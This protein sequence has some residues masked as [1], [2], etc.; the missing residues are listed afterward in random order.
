[1][2]KLVLPLAVHTAVRKA[3][4]PQ[5]ARCH[6]LRHAFATHRLEA[7]Y[8]I[9]TIQARLGHRDVSTTMIDTSVPH[10]G[11]RGVMPPADLLGG[12]R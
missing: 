7:G 2:H 12:S 4:L 1:M 11:G 8:D 9:R 6:T 10:R 3:N 5:P